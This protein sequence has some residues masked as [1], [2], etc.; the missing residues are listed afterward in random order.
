MPK[1]PE[2]TRRD[3]L[4]IIP[5]FGYN[6]AAQKVFRSVRATLAAEGI[7]VYVPTYIERGGLAESRTELQ[8]FLHEHHLGQ[9]QRL[10]VFAFIAGAWTLNPMLERERPANL[11]TVIYDRSPMQERAPRVADEKLHFLTWVKFGRNVFDM[12][13]TPYTPDTA[14][15]VR[16]GIMVET[17]PTKLMKRYAKPVL[18]YGPLHFECAAFGQR[19]NDCTYLALSHDQLYTRF[20]E[21]VP[22]VLTFM[23]TG[24]YS[25]GAN[26]AP[27]THDPLPMPP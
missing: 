5:G 2:P 24:R 6:R 11:A 26:R 14:A 25:A 21:L 27:P 3:A 8:E 13:R 16:I 18:S 15:G 20:Q 1:S 12:A 17:V 22:E 10:H 19:Y 23:R 4:L 9:Y 7:D